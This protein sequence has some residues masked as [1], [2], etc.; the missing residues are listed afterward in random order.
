MDCDI[1]EVSNSEAQAAE[2][3][4][5]LHEERMQ[6]DRLRQE[7]ERQELQRLQQ[8]QDLKRQ[9]QIH[10]EDR[11]LERKRQESE[12][13]EDTEERDLSRRQFLKAQQDRLLIMEIGLKAS[14]R[15]PAK[16]DDQSDS[17]SDPEEKDIA[18]ENGE[19]IN[20]QGQIDDA[21][22]LVSFSTQTPVAPTKSLTDQLLSQLDDMF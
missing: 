4:R 10:E 8:E 12:G 5:R 18:S 7:R 6:Q 19:E 11:R 2:D 21:Q 1:D 14:L 16:H 22:L 9:Q 20:G 17:D 3:D 13:L 15:Q